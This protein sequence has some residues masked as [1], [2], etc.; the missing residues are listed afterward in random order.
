MEK[1]E[2]ERKEKEK[3]Q[4]LGGES[5]FEK[6][7]SRKTEDYDIDR[8]VIPKSM[9]VT[10]IEVLK[11]EEIPT[12]SFKNLEPDNSKKSMPTEEIDLNEDISDEAF[13]LRHSKAEVEERKRLTQPLYSGNIAYIF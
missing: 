3:K 10:K 13:I 9:Y 8:I 5:E 4:D 11:Y 7:N 2:R 12:P 1:Q 6:P